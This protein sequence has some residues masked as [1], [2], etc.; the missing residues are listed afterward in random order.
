MA[1]VSATLV[2]WAAA[3]RYGRAASDDV[4][5]ALQV[6]ADVH[7]VRAADP[8]TA[9]ALDLPGSG[10]PPAAPALLLA[11]LR[12]ADLADAG[13]VL[14]IPGDVRGLGGKSSFAEDAMRAGEAVLLASAGLGIVPN[15]VSQ[16]EVQWTVY[17]L[18]Q[19]TGR[20][21]TPLSQAEHDLSGSMRA[22]A[23][24]LIELGVAKARPNVRE[25]IAE[26]VA[27]N[28]EVP[29]PDGM[30]GR[31]VRVLAR[32][33]ELDAILWVA[34]G[35]QPGS[36]LS[37]RTAQAREQVLQPLISAVR[38]ARC[39]AVDE[40]VRAL[41]EQAEPAEQTEPSSSN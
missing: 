41:S 18:P 30:P 8:R 10:E 3:W 24:A 6:W 14:P 34:S 11:A 29:W 4:L 20:E 35:D 2:V 9:A 13:I 21:H 7:R 28:P 33:A 26:H 1:S 25:E 16:D 15:K 23:T 40:A 12:N 19:L 32:A 27:R 39:A 22:A 37:A 5:D 38:S 17:T 36:A 31:A